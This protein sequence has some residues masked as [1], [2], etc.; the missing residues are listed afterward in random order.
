MTAQDFRQ[1]LELGLNVF[2]KSKFSDNWLSFQGISM[3]EEISDTTEILVLQGSGC[4][5]NGHDFMTLARAAIDLE[6]YAANAES[7]KVAA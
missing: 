5:G 7:W 1:H 4:V 2:V 3:S 6:M